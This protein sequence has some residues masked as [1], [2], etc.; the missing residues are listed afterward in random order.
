MDMQKFA[1][2]IA[3]VSKNFEAFKSRNDAQVAALLERL[4]LIEAGAD[5]SGA[6]GS[7]SETA[8]AREHR[9]RFDLW[10]RSP[11]DSEAKNALSEFESRERR[12]INIGTPADGGHAVPTEIAREIE[13]HELKLSP[14]RRIC[15]VVKV[16]TSDYKHLLDLRGSQAGW[17]GESG[18]RTETDTPSLRERAPTMGELYAYPSTSE[19]ALQDIFFDVAAWLA[20]AVAEEFSRLEGDAVIRGDGSN[21][22][23]GMLD[24]PPTTVSDGASPARAAAVYQYLASPSLVSPTVYSVDPDKLIDLQHEV[25]GSYR[26]EAVWVMNS[27]TQ[28]HIRKLKDA[29]GRWLWQPALSAG[30]PP[31][32]LGHAVE[33]WEQMDDIGANAFPIAFGN[34]RRGYLIA[35]RTELRISVDANITQPGRI[36]YY[37]RRREA[38]CPLNNDAIKFLRTTA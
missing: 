18:P 16:S 3:D 1:A 38:G 15:K 26:S 25:N 24:A 4:E 27:A 34:F 8:M 37:V 20:E 17:V 33:T 28:G 12:S 22:P 13:R 23:T 9:K 29:E 5:R 19:W 2:A 10:I 32:L 30:Q 35:D 7:R 14:V 31:T 6:T 11:H 36:K 21:K